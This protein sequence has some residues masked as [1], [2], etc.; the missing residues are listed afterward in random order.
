MSRRKT[1][2]LPHTRS[3][4]V[5]G[6]TLQLSYN[7]VFPPHLPSPS[8]CFWTDGKLAARLCDLQLGFFPLP[9]NRLRVIQR[10][11]IFLLP[12]SL[13]ALQTSLHRSQLF[14]QL[15]NCSGWGLLP[16]VSQHSSGH[17]WNKAQRDLTVVALIRVTRQ[18]K[19]SVTAHPGHSWIRRNQ[20]SSNAS[21]ARLIPELSKNAWHFDCL[22]LF[23]RQVFPRWVVKNMVS[24][25]SSRHSGVSLT[26][27]LKGLR[28]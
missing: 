12:A 1:P 20:I 14:Q 6:S 13:P 3:V 25:S 22:E 8:N 10:E 11:L 26:V 9:P 16:P 7:L 21:R 27:I 4:T 19:S 15:E 2:V 17:N 18:Y 5:A 23:F 24:L 28:S